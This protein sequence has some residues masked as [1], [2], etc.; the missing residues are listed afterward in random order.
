MRRVIALA[1]VLAAGVGVAPRSAR[2][3]ASAWAHAPT[4]TA[5]VRAGGTP[6]AFSS[7]V[8][9]EPPTG[10]ARGSADL[11][12]LQGLSLPD[13]PIRWDDRVVAYLEHFR[14]D[15]RGRQS[16]AAWLR[17]AHPHAPMIRERLRALGLPQGL[18]YVAMVES[19]FDPTARSPAGAVGM[20]QFVRAT[21]AQ[22]GLEADHWV[23][24]R[25]D[26][27]ASTEAAARYLRDLHRRFGT[28]ELALAAYNMGYGSLLR[29]IRKYNTNDFWVLA[30]VEAGLPYETTLYVAKVMACALVGEN[31]ERFG[32]DPSPA[33]PPAPTDVVRVP[34]GMPL[35]L[36]ARAAQVPEDDLARL[37]PELL[38]GRT[39]PGNTAYA[40]RIPAASADGFH[41]RWARLRPG[42]PSHRRHVLKFGETLAEVAKRY[43][44][45]AARLARLNALDDASTVGAG[46][47]LLV[48]AVEPREL[49]ADSAP[50]VVSVPAGEFLYPDRR[51]LF[52]RVAGHDTAEDIAGFFQVTVDELRRWNAVDP[53]AAFV[54]GMILQ[55]F[56]PP[57]VDLSHAVVLGAEEVRVLTL[58]TEEF[59]AYHEQ[60]KGRVRFRYTVQPG[61][62]LESLAKRFGLATADLTRINRFPRST[63]L[64]L[65]QEIIVYAPADKAPPDLAATTR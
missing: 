28:W 49:E 51:R 62:T 59:F 35:A 8:T 64:E 21:G 2:A 16:M 54:E 23:D 22:Y 10:P 61:D 32:F 12:W 42:E 1:V 57:E 45:T 14:K 52:Y 30:Q 40:L 60:Q 9:D 25:K 27:D 56:V 7:D 4:L 53:G 29:T 34:G 63:V 44:T 48:P 15:P 38:R 20:W 47:A 50:P 19:G 43:R 39:P 13:I 3:D 46:T 33:E 24:R 55:L 11:G 37:N 6:A 58:G 26:P 31:P 36:L 17:R 65:G 18:M 5:N 41:A